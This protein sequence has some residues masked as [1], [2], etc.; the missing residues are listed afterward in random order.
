MSTQQDKILPFLGLCKIPNFKKMILVEP[1]NLSGFLFT[2]NEDHN[3]W[4]ED[5]FNPVLELASG[6]W[7]KCSANT[8]E[9]R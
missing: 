6:I 7:R 4:Q 8:V 3:L 1:V 2:T 9:K 5:K